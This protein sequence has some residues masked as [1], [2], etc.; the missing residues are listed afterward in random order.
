MLLNACKAFDGSKM[1]VRLLTE[2]CFIQITTSGPGI[3]KGRQVCM[4]ICTSEA[5]QCVWEL[6]GPA[7]L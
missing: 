6:E 1:L 4:A 2:I 5:R 3:R 7:L